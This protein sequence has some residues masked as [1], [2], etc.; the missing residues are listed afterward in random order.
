MISDD[1]DRVRG[2][3]K[4]V[5]PFREGK[6]DSKEFSVI[7]VVVVLSKGESLREVGTG[8]KVTIGVFCI[9]TAPAA[10]RDASVMRENGLETSGMEKTGAE[11]KSCLRISNAHC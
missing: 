8:M 6:D 9:R 10:R 3:L 11:K 5:L 1:G 7:N 4:I 2:S